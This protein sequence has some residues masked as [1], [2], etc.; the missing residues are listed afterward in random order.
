[1]I[2][3]TLKTWGKDSWF[4]LTLLSGKVDERSANDMDDEKMSFAV[5]TIATLASLFV[6]FFLTAVCILFRF[7]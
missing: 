4:A 6:L 7:G 5:L 2:F 3:K 1:M